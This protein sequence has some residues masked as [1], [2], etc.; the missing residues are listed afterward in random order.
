MDALVGRVAFDENEGN[1]RRGVALEATQQ[2]V[3]VFRSSHNFDV[4]A[5]GHVFAA[6]DEFSL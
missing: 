6:L 2:H 4:V 3:R 1:L 5:V